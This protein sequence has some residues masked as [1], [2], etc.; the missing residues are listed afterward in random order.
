MISIK[1][2]TN[3]SDIPDDVSYIVGIIILEKSSYC[4]LNIEMSNQRAPLSARNY[5]SWA[6][7][8]HKDSLHWRGPRARQPVQVIVAMA[9][10]EPF[11]AAAVASSS[12]RCGS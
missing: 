6:K 10:P 5:R 12:H 3:I 8:S 2:R 1:L 4:S 9:T 7:T 11:L